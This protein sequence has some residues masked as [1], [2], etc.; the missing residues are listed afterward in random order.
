M[1]KESSLRLKDK[2][3]LVLGGNGDVGGAIAKG[4]CHEGAHVIATRRD[5]D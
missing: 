5:R 3:A 2:V 4:L 1:K